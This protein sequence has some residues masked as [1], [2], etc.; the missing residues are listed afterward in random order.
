MYVILGS[1]PVFIG[2]L[3]GSFFYRKMK[4]KKLVMLALPIMLLSACTFAA[5]GIASTLSGLIQTT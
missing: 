4:A 1:V 3:L 2:C 5:W